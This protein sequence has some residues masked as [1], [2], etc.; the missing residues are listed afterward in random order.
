MLKNTEHKKRSF[1][2]T[3]EGE[4]NLCALE[5]FLEDSEER[6]AYYIVLLYLDLLPHSVFA[7]IPKLTFDKTTCNS[8][9]S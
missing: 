2:Y 7:W 1:A 5:Y 3:R 9:K 6:N 8:R 4:N